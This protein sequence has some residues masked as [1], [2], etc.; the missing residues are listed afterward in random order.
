MVIVKTES[1]ELLNKD[2]S[3][4][5]DDL[6]VYKFR[7]DQDSIIRHKRSPIIPIK[8][9]RL[10]KYI[11][12]FFLPKARNKPRP[13]K[14]KKPSIAKPDDDLTYENNIP[15][16]TPKQS[17][18]ASY[19]YK[20]PKKTKTTTSK[21]FTTI[22][23]YYKY[24]TNNDIVTVKI[25]AEDAITNPTNYNSYSTA[26]AITSSPSTTTSS[27]TTFTTTSTTSTTSSSTT[28]TSLTTGSYYY[29]DYES[30]TAGSYYYKDDESAST[31][32][33]PITTSLVLQN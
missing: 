12:S 28:T 7:A 5:S 21:P 16:T 20:Y 31:T 15:S 33:A 27:T 26:K 4:L 8:E 13:A 32:M 30:A 18:T 10:L 11:K 3:L 2:H 6:N 23:Y 17:T 19:Y 25:K 29:K 9:S 14:M 1:L 24:L 22:S